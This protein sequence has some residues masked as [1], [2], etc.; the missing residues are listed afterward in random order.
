[1]SHT[2]ITSRYDKP[3][4]DILVDFI[5]AHNNTRFAPTDLFFGDPV[6]KSPYGLTEVQL[7]LNSEL[8]FQDQPKTLT[9]WRVDIQD[10]ARQSSLTIHSTDQTKEGLIKALFKQ[11]GL[12][13]ESDLVDFTQI[14]QPIQENLSIPD[15]DGFDPGSGGN[16]ELPEAGNMTFRLSFSD[17]HLIFIGELTVHVRPSI[18]LLDKGIDSRMDLRAFYADGRTDLPPVDLLIPKGELYVSE[19][20]FP[21]SLRRKI[22]LVLYSYKTDTQL[23]VENTLPQL[24]HSLTHDAWVSVDRD[25]PFN[26]YGATVVYN[27]FVTVDEPLT[28]ESY[29]YVLC[30]RLSNR[31]SNLRGLLK[32]GYRYASS[33]VPGDQ[34]FDHGYVPPVTVRF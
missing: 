6:A 8:G 31:C 26:L 21:T 16:S 12:Y 15:L 27:G 25:A 18:T 20:V 22:E 5:N 4:K 17:Q 19:D 7:R 30:L 33:Q 13:L 3:S 9:Y 24:L 11:C 2:P 29:N 28:C 32:I 1:M 10:A 23:G 34:K 14:P